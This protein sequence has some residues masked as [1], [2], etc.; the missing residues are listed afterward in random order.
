M[1][2]DWLDYLLGGQGY[3]MAATCVVHLLNAGGGIS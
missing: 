3:I 1:N 2:T